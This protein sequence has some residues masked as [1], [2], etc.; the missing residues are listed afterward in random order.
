M[1]KPNNKPLWINELV[2]S[3]YLLFSE[4]KT[5][6]INIY[7]PEERYQ[8]FADKNQMMRVLNNIISNAIQAIPDERRGKIEISVFEKGENV[9]IKVSDNGIG[10]PD[11]MHEKVF[12]PH[13][14][15]R[16]SGMGLGLA[17]CKDIVEMGGGKIYFK[18]V[19]E[20]GTDFFVELPKL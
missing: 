4:N 5:V 12:A 10:I 15:T 16:S 9:V 18:T 3:V 7:V 6:D 11:E 20:K 1:P 2:E 19:P 13:F 14:T 8:V 17:M